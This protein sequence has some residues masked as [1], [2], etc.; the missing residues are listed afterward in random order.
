MPNKSNKNVES[1][2]KPGGFPYQ[3]MNGPEESRYLT[4][5]RNHS[6]YMVPRGFMDY[7][8]MVGVLVRGIL[9]NFLILLSLLLV[10]SLVIGHLYGPQLR[11]LPSSADLP[12]TQLKTLAGKLIKPEGNY[13]WLAEKLSAETRATLKTAKDRPKDFQRA[14]LKDLR[15][16]IDGESLGATELFKPRLEELQF[17]AQLK[18]LAMKSIKE[19]GDF[20]ELLATMLLG[21]AKAIKA[22]ETA[23]DLPKDFQHALLKDL[24]GL[25]GNK[26]RLE[27][28]KK[29][30]EDRSA[31][32]GWWRGWM[33]TLSEGSRSYLWRE[34]RLLLEDAYPEL[35]K[36]PKEA[37]LKIE[38]EGESRDSC[39]YLFL[40]RENRLFLEVFVDAY[41]ELKKKRKKECESWGD[42]F[43][44]WI[45]KPTENN[46]AGIQGAGPLWETGLL[47][48]MPVPFTLT[49]SVLLLAML[50]I[51]A[52]PIMVLYREIAGHKKSV[53]RAGSDSS[54]KLRDKFERIFG[55]FLLA[56]LAF[57]LFE[58]LPVLVDK[59][60][61]F[62]VS[63]EMNWWNAIF[64]SVA[65]T[66]VAILGGA[67]KLL[68]ILGGAKKKLA[69]LLIG[70]LGL[71]VPLLVV[72][73]V[74][75]F[76]V[77]SP[78]LE[79]MLKYLHLVLP[80]AFIVLIGLGM[81]VGHRK[82]SFKHSEQAKLLVIALAVSVV[83][84]VIW[85]F[86]ESYEQRNVAHE[87]NW[88]FVAIGAFE[89]WLFCRLAVDINR[90]S[91]HGL[92]R[93]RLAS[94]YLVGLDSEGDVDI[95]EDINL[96]EIGRYEAGSTAPYHL[97]NVTL[98]LQG[99]KDISI[100][101]RN[102]DFFIFSKRFIGGDRTGYCRTQT[103]EQVHP[104]MSLATAMAISAAA[105][106]PNMGRSTNPP[107]V[108]LM[109]LLN[110]RLGYW[111][112][113]PG[114]LEEK[115]SHRGLFE[116]L[117]S[118][119]KL[120]VKKIKREPI[121]TQKTPPGFTFEEV[122]AQELVDI[123]KRWNNVY[124]ESERKH[125]GLHETDGKP[126]MT[127]TTKHGLVG[128]GFSGGGI[129]SATINLGIA[130][131]LHERGV[132]DHVDYMSTVSGGGYLGS[133]ISTLMR[134]TTKPVGKAEGKPDFSMNTREYCSEIAGVVSIDTNTMG[135]KIV[136]VTDMSAP[137]EQHEYRFSRFDPLVIEDGDTVEAGQELI[138][139]QT[140]LWDRFRWR[141][142]PLA[143]WR[144]MMMKLDECHKWVNLSDG[145]HIENLAGI[146]L[147][148]RRCK[149]I[150]IGDGEA[151]PELSFNGL[152][153]LIRYARID[154]GIKIDI[155]PDAIRVDKSKG[156]VDKGTD[157]L[158]Q[159]HWAFGTITYPPN[160]NNEHVQEKGYLLYL[161]S[162][163]TGDE[164]EVIKEYRHRNPAFPHQSTADQFFD[165]NQFECYR[166][167]G[168]HIGEEALQEMSILEAGRLPNMAFEV[169]ES[170][171]TTRAKMNVQLAE[172]ALHD[173][174]NEK[175]DTWLEAQE[176][177]GKW[178]SELPEEET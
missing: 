66:S 131:A 56:I 163:Y 40:W 6:N 175:W 4:W 30:V 142:R 100:R 76:V 41:P 133:S 34:N 151:D 108:A 138:E 135:E 59:F 87:W 159:E 82:G 157:N 97:V 98:N 172:A 137:S 77:Y 1:K 47:P 35:K 49:R 71:L 164:D 104:T 162:S 46:E 52:S 13:K 127:P 45:W 123:E 14:L 168:Q 156:A 61:Q 116:A 9:L 153:T 36:K 7:F 60:H 63:P 16:L 96:G 121:A 148:R 21:K 85:V 102:S 140:T 150:I 144:E 69:M 99:S 160:E 83:T 91:I 19:K 38:K 84:I 25:D 55:F 149:F 57:G 145:G 80:L 88:W 113:N 31:T 129:R 54:V 117:S 167:L 22:L 177:I 169:F 139:P 65:G 3:L 64:A 18:T 48:P 118:L 53:E 130:Q 11:S 43:L 17:L 2:V 101:D 122:F 134:R 37:D 28:L 126:T 132:F 176:K 111:L 26:P 95:E 114:L 58:T 119:G 68:S 110:I 20:H 109:V 124:P 12:L 75:H 152:A 73:Y 125:R 120:V 86:L 90:T 29:A 79:G 158:S 62:M 141:V 128:I 165:E 112:P 178:S 93:D 89:L 147:L 155:H 24:R 92:Y 107:L 39:E 8:R 136:K 166:A 115:L 78:G 170:G 32:L 81:A 72:L 5:L 143:L 23:E 173:K 10:I 74:T 51:L 94:A 146:E 67:S 42:R 33:K 174:V 154:L 70:L 15:G 44:V 50:V 105:A 106:S 161:K 171:L 103:L 27:E